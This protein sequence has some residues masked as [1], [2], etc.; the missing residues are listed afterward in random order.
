MWSTNPLSPPTS[1]NLRLLVDLIAQQNNLGISTNETSIK[2]NNN[3]IRL[4]EMPIVYDVRLDE[5]TKMTLFEV[6][7]YLVLYR[8]SDLSGR[9]LMIAIHSQIDDNDFFLEEFVTSEFSG[10]M[11]QEVSAL[12]KKIIYDQRNF[13][14]EVQLILPTYSNLQMIKQR[15]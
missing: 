5:H 11:Y 15:V 7:K 6:Q 4:H 8:Q 1:T 9:S 10:Q 13:K 3:L 2:H 14:E 12:I